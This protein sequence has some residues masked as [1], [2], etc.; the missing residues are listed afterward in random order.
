MEESGA[1]AVQV[2]VRERIRRET[3]EDVVSAG[4]VRQPEIARRIR[5]W[6]RSDE[7]LLDAVLDWV[8]DPAIYD[9]VQ[10]VLSS[11]RHGKGRFFRLGTG[12]LVTAAELD[13]RAAVKRSSWAT[14]LEHVGDRHIPLNLM[15][16]RDCETAATERRQRAESELVNAKFFAA[17]AKGL[18]GNQT[19]GERWTDDEIA[20][21][22]ASITEPTPARQK[23]KAA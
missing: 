13:R 22:H 10:S 12:E 7:A 17:L 16:R 21:L 6:V 23:E 5:R 9:I 11:T 2:R 3:L 8:F 19:V 18:R 4:S 1:I 14:W 20:A 15:T